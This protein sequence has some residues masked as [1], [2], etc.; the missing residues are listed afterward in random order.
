VFRVTHCATLVR[1][2]PGTCL[3]LAC[4]AFA[5]ACSSLAGTR[6]DLLPEFF[7]PPAT[8]PWFT[9]SAAPSIIEKRILGSECASSSTNTD[10]SGLGLMT[11]PETRGGVY[12]DS[13]TTPDGTRWFLHRNMDDPDITYCGIA[14]AGA[15]KGTN[16]SVTGIRYRDLPEAKAAVEFGDFLCE[17]KRMAQ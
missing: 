2:L 1:M 6:P 16:V 8:S 14:L 17:C 11:R 12:L 4:A 7:A 3:I 15:A 13:G 5:T 9:V 10:V